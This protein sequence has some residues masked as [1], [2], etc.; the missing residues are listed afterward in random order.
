MASSY[1]LGRLRQII[2]QISCFNETSLQHTALLYPYHPANNNINT[3][4]A[5]IWS[6]S[7]PT[8]PKFCVPA[9]RYSQ[10]KIV[11][12]GL[13]Q[14]HHYA[15]LIFDFLNP[16]WLTY[17]ENNWTTEVKNMPIPAAEEIGLRLLDCWNRGF[18]S[19]RGHG[20]SSL[21]FVVCSVGSDL[22][23]ELIFRSEVSYR[24]RARACVCV[25]NRVS[26]RN[27]NNGA[28]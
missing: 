5:N 26:S 18:E 24:A 13:N 16:V 8:L 20:C 27:L 19:R 12:Q 25:S 17:W 2:T 3:G 11:G 4:H 1:L 14:Q 7:V 15:N 28:A 21:T 22:C 6:G 10:L 9:V 23:D